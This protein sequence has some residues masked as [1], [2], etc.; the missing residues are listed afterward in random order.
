MDF[1]AGY[2]FRL[3]KKVSYPGFEATRAKAAYAISRKCEKHAGEYRENG[4][5]E[6][7]DP[8]HYRKRKKGLVLAFE[9]K[10]KL[11][12]TCPLLDRGR[13]VLLVI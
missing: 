11:L 1:L 7:R 8:L 12:R 13:Y 5:G 10:F 9:P 4:A 3:Y 2:L 6:D